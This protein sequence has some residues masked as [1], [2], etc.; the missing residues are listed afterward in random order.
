[1]VTLIH[2]IMTCV[3]YFTMFLLLFSNMYMHEPQ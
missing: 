3:Q 1:M 2:S